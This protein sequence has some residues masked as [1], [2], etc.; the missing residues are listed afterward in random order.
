VAPSW[1][2]KVLV[3]GGGAY[4]IGSSVEFDWCCVNTVRAAQELGYE[5]ILL[6]YNPE[7]VSTDYDVCDKLVFDEISL[8]TVLDLWRA[9]A[10]RR[11]GGVDGRTGAQ[12]PRAQAPP[13]GREGARHQPR[14]HRPRGGSREVPTCSTARTS[15]S[16]GG[17]TTVGRRDRAPR[18]VTEGLGGYPLLVRPSYVLSG[19]A[20]TVAHEPH[21]LRNYLTAATLVSPEHPVVIT[22]FETNA[23]EIEIDAVADRGEIDPLGH[24]R[25]HRER[26]RA[27]RRRDARAAAA[28]A[29]RRDHPAHQAH[30]P[31]RGPRAGDH[32]A[33]Q[34]AV[35]G[36]GQ[37]GQGD[38]VQPPGVALLPLRLE[39]HRGPTS[40]ARPRDGCWAWRR[41]SP[42]RRSTSTTWP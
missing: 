3:L 26:R 7:T 12:Q 36:G 39:G 42:S 21:H 32:R 14:L 11:G 40:S 28:E 38:R 30:R 2:K 22:K 24:L 8:E 29:L 6:N 20:M 23:K 10:A 27:L 41:P 13:R 35:P 4:R 18:P 17:R 31:R 9:R 15:T 25:A 19:A 37:R 5:T 1:R 16:R 34:H 33:L